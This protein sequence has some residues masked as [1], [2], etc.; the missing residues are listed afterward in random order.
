[1]RF[2]KRVMQDGENQIGYNLNFPEHLYDRIREFALKNKCSMAFIIQNAVED[3]LT[4]QQN[5]QDHQPT[6]EKE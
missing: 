3:Y 5:R 2:K 4:Q 1:M 6:P